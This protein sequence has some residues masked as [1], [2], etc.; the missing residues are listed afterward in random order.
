M[1]KPGLAAEAR[2]QQKAALYQDACAA[3]GWKFQPIVAECTGVWNS[4]GRKFVGKLARL[5]AQRKGITIQSAH[6]HAWQV[7]SVA[8]AHQVASQL[9]RAYQPSILAPEGPPLLM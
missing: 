8:V 1:G 9:A 7:L 5:F 6:A 3:V 4:S 2:S